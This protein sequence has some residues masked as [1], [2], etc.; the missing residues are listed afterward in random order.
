[1]KFINVL[2][3]ALP[4]VSAVTQTV[5]VLNGGLVKRR[6]AAGAKAVKG[7]AGLFMIPLKE[8]QSKTV[9]RITHEVIDVLGNDDQEIIWH[10]HDY[11][12]TLPPSR[13]GRNCETRT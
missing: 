5:Q 12:C 2:T 6:A 13:A 9:D 10:N 7:L 1:M 4:T 11:R 3:L 8:F